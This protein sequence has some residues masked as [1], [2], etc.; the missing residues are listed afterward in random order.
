MEFH[1]R[2]TMQT[3]TGTLRLKLQ[4][5]PRASKKLIRQ[6]RDR[7]KTSLMKKSFEYSTMCDADVCLGIRIRETG[8]VYIFSADTTGFWAFVGAQ[9]VNSSDIYIFSMADL[10]RTP[11][12]QPQIKSPKR[13]S[14][15]R[16]IKV[17]WMG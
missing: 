11:I 8:R 5:S 7:R 9:L 13:T 17:W 10:P 1:T 16:K 12:T 14:S 4:K 3:K 15:A 6:K 2:K